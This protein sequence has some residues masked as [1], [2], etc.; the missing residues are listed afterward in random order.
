MTIDKK[1]LENYQ[2]CKIFIHITF[3]YVKYFF[4]ARHSGNDVKTKFQDLYVRL[5]N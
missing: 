4:V 1:L 2:K 3:F 5:L